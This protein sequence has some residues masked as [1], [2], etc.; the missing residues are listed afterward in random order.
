MNERPYRSTRDRKV[1]GVCGGLA[2]RLDIDPSVVRVGWV[3]L[4]LLAAVRR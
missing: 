4:A 1:A 3:L 2:G